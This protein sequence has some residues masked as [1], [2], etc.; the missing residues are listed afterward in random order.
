M[1]P[2][3]TP[4]GVTHFLLLRVMLPMLPAPRLPAP[5]ALP[6]ITRKLDPHPL[7]PH[8]HPALRLTLHCCFLF[9]LRS[10]NHLKCSMLSWIQSNTLFRCPTPR[11]PRLCVT[12]TNR[13]AFGPTTSIVNVSYSVCRRYFSPRNPTGI[14][15]FVGIVCMLLLSLFLLPR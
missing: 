3:T 9:F 11:S 14:Q 4:T 8:K 5:R 6:T 1:N 10:H 2:E 7:L 15:K 13:I 12:V